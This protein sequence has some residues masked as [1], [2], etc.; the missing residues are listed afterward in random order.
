[1]TETPETERAPE[2]DE[3]LMQLQIEDAPEDAPEEQD[4]V[5]EVPEDAPE[6]APEGAPE[7]APEESAADET[8]EEP[9]ET[10]DSRGVDIS[11]AVVETEIESAAQPSLPLLARLRDMCAWPFIAYAA[12]WLLF[13]VAVVFGLR[14]SA[15]QGTV[16]GS[17][18]YPAGVIVG[19]AL[20]AA[21]PLLVLVVWLVAR[22]AEGRSRTGLLASV[23]LRGAAATLFGVALWWAALLLLDFFRLGALG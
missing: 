18:Y 9:A 13:A 23:S 6:D 8:A 20:A 19:A 12:I 2:P 16:V 5:E 14:P 15:L 10:A 21:G 17:P 4:V 7:E 3:E 22:R 1:M 11:P